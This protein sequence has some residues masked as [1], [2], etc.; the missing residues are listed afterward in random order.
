MR[1]VLLITRPEPGATRTANA[2][3]QAAG[4]TFQTVISPLLAMRF[5]AY[6]FW[7]AL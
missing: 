6:F 1:P 4:D 3:R 2:L 5:R 7:L